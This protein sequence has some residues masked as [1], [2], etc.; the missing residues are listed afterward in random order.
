MRSE[1]I[2]RVCHEALRVLQSI[3]ND[4]VP[5]RPWEEAPDYQRETAQLAVIRLQ[6][7]KSTP[8]EHHEQWRVHMI[9]MGWKYGREKNLEAKTH[10]CLVPYDRLPDEQKAKDVLFLAIVAALSG[11]SLAGLHDPLR[12]ILNLS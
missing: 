5:A 8:A 11:F 9:Q 7:E 1:D 10:P 6:E 4:P 2:A 3:Q 12:M